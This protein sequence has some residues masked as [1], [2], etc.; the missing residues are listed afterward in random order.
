MAIKNP[1][2]KPGFFGGRGKAG[3][4]R[5]GHL[6]GAAEE[7]AE[8]LV[9]NFA[10]AD[11]S[12]GIA[13]G[14]AAVFGIF[15]E[16]LGSV[17]NFGDRPFSHVGEG[18]TF[19]LDAHGSDLALLEEAGLFPDAGLAELPGDGGTG[20]GFEGFGFEA[21]LGGGIGKG[22]A[23]IR[24]GL[25]ELI[26]DF[27]P[28]FGEEAAFFGLQELLGNGLAN[29]LE[30]GH[31]GRQG[32]AGDEDDGPVI[33]GGDIGEVALGIRE[34]DPHGIEQFGGNVVD[35]RCLIARVGIEL[36]GL[37]GEGIDEALVSI[38]F[39]GNLL[40][41]KL[42]TEI[43]GLTGGDFTGFFLDVILPDLILNGFESQGRFGGF[44]GIVRIVFR[45]FGAELL[46]VLGLILIKAGAK[47]FLGG[48]LDL[49]PVVIS[50]EE[51]GGDLDS[52]GNFVAAR[53][54]LV[55][56]F[57]FCSGGLQLGG[58]I[59]IVEMG[60]GHLV[61]SLAIAVILT[62][63]ER[64]RIIGAGHGL[65]EF[66]D[67]VILAEDAG[68]HGAAE[69]GVGLEGLKDIIVG[70]GGEFTGLAILKER[71]G[72]DIILKLGIG[73]LRDAE[74]VGH[75]EGSDA[76]V[77][78]IH[79]LLATEAQLGMQDGGDFGGLGEGTLIGFRA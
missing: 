30:G 62:N 14:I 13:H 45:F 60:E 66:A 8:I 39:V 58:E 78:V 59:L 3:K 28:L 18:S 76:E 75:T 68:E 47:F 52:F 23:G 79:H 22:S 57:Q 44:G 64:E 70:F 50:L 26:V 67:A 49:V 10:E 16:L 7:A 55:E 37:D 74:P 72:F 1:G 34:V 32:A 51:E 4:C 19:L 5:S 25:G 38:A 20:E 69:A 9:G 73:G 43:F 42:H 61:G 40:L 65:A 35:G 17:V 2:G 56:G 41:P 12:E 48:F 31:P 15:G 29:F 46:L 54:F 24:D 6:D 33:V 71:N 63:G 53:V 36:A 27:L 21:Q 11:P 77:G